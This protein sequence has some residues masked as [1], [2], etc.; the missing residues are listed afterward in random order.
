M[1]RK[2]WFRGDV[3]QVDLPAHTRSGL[4]DAMNRLKDI[5]G[6]GSVRLTNA[7]IV[8]HPLVQE[9]VRAYDENP[10]KRR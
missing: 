8:R 6:F 3:T 5:D 7:D 9:I 10:K 4:S 1:V 2:L